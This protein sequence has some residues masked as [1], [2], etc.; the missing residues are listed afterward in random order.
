MVYRVIGLM[1]GSSM[2]GLDIVFTQL[3]EVGGKWSYAV[4]AAECVSYPPEMQIRLTN[5]THLNAYDYL[6]LDA[7]LG[8]LIGHLVASFMDR[9]ELR[10][11]VQLIALHGH[12]TFHEPAKG[13]SAWLGD[14][15][16]V[17]AI[18]KT[19][20]VS[21]LRS[22][23]VALG[24]QGAPIV[25]MGERLLFPSFQYFLNIGGIANIS[26][27]KE[28]KHVAFDVCPANKVL[29]LLAKQK[30]LD[31][32]RDGAI[33]ASGKMDTALLT[34][35]NKLEYYK[36]AY[37]KS[38]ANKFGIEEVFPMV[39]KAPISLED[40]MRTYVEHICV[41]ITYAIQ[42]AEGV[43]NGTSQKLLVT[44]GGAL[45]TFLIQR[46][47]K[48]LSSYNIEVVVPDKETVQYKEA[49][50]MALLATLRWREEVTVM[51]QISGAVRPGIGGAVWI[52]Q[53]Y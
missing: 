23:D 26:I 24:G 33:A 43:I 34:A 32:D 28:N 2:D 47:S 41:Q 20:V 14:A 17:A 29:N 16:H 35:L 31:Y 22:L 3:E 51:H 52:G 53:D 13:F 5:S 6:Q 30:G 48:V 7:D 38:L 40:K 45:N 27:L 18:T 4:L 46:L 15:A 1:S 37:P 21:H 49:L 44:G 19:N 10:F 25:P 8:K 36:Q 50:I 39:D 9:Y 12:T 11:K 42:Q